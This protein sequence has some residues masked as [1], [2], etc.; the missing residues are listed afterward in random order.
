[1]LPKKRTVEHRL[2][3]EVPCVRRKVGSIMAVTGSPNANNFTGTPIRK[4]R[5]DKARKSREQRLA[6]S[7]SCHVAEQVGLKWEQ[8][9]TTHV[10]N[11][12]FP[13]APIEM[14]DVEITDR[15]ESVTNKR[16]YSKGYRL[17]MR[18]HAKVSNKRKAKA[19]KEKVASKLNRH[20]VDPAGSA[21][22]D[23][24]TEVINS[25][26]WVCHQ[27]HRATKGKGKVPYIALVK[28]GKW[29]KHIALK[30]CRN[31]IEALAQLQAVHN[32]TQMA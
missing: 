23:G 24:A 26:E 14:P 7:K 2:A 22:L 18:M 10:V 8:L 15:G 1:M 12:D 13:Y 25:N 21:P 29:V 28:N 11:R 16:R 30:P 5:G 20:T 17:V 3:A 32:V 31:R 4:R 6:R 19:P 27:L 9:D